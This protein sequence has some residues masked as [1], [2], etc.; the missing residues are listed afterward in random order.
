MTHVNPRKHCDFGLLYLGTLSLMV[1]C[2]TQHTQSQL[3]NEWTQ[4]ATQDV[5]RDVSLPS[6]PDAQPADANLAD[7]IALVQ[8]PAR[9]T[10]S[11]RFSVRET[12][13]QALVAAHV[14]V[15]GV[16]G[17][18][19]P[20]LGPRNRADG[21]LQVRIAPTGEGTL[22]LPVGAYRVSFD[23]GP[24][25]SIFS[26]RV[27]ITEGTAQSLDASIEHL[28][29]M[30]DWTAC[31]LHV[32]AERSFDSRVSIADR[33]ASLTSVGIEFATPTE[34]NVVGDYRTG[35]E[36]LPAAARGRQGASGPGLV[37]VPAVEVTTDRAE[38]PIGHFNV[39]PFR[40][41]ARR[42]D[43]GAPDPTLSATEIFRLA[44][45]NTRDAIIQ[46]NHPRMETNIGYFTRTA[47]E[48]QR[49]S[50][51]SPR[52]DPGYTAIEVFNGYYLG[53]P[54]EVDRVLH[55]WLDLLSSGARYVGTANSDSH[56]IAYETAGYPR[57]YV[58]TPRAGD[59]SPTAARV[60]SALRNGH[61]FGTSGPMLTLAM[62]RAMMGDTVRLPPS[63]QSAR[64]RVHLWAAP[65][66]DVDLI[67]IYRDRELS[68][69]IAVPT[70]EAIERMDI[71]VDIP[72]SQA[73]HSVV[74]VARGDR[75]MNEVL[76]RLQARPFA[77][78]NPLWIERRIA[79]H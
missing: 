70:T 25:W 35:V 4:G 73:R 46:V 14:V 69:T 74:A 21:A 52:Y 59:A 16:E 31:D 36:A 60:L 28:L 24:E 6:V 78:T 76:P 19:D 57:T 71:E 13:T 43:G 62:G 75:P 26:A 39:F 30:G 67:E 34:H 12:L 77:F 53:N 56:Y 51:E 47:L 18:L 33:V 64:V 20:D 22:T 41:T 40:P 38:Y 61:V 27:A 58:Y 15:R 2:S 55:D 63:A 29:A 9:P 3:G 37:W 1:G 42:S 48:P 44:R 5:T 45:A 65:W 50:S 66:I 79:S 17:T 49:N 54:L 7:A 8:P 68:A 72:L 23:H 11:L 10:G 32:H